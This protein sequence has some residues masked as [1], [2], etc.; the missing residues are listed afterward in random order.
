[1]HSWFKSYLSNRMQYVSVN[2]CNSSKLPVS[3]GVPHGSVL[4]PLLFFYINDI[5]NSIPGEKIKLFADDTNLFIAAKSVEV[6]AN[7]HLSNG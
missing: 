7:L 6:K 4:G 1:M 2:S 3:C 5:Y